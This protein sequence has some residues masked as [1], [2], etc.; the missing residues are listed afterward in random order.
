M[1][2]YRNQGR[3]ILESPSVHSAGSRGGTSLVTVK[4]LRMGKAMSTR[5][6]AQDVEVVVK[7]VV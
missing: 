7:E 1:L 3:K 4:R 5:R 2:W 6:S